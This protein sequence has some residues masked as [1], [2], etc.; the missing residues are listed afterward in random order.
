MVPS[1]TRRRAVLNTCALL[2]ITTTSEVAV[3][4]NEWRSKYIKEKLK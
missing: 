2:L 1:S 3:M 4:E